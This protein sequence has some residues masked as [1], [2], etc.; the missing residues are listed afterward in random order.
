M[1]GRLS[2][3]RGS[4]LVLRGLL[5]LGLLL[6]GVAGCRPAAEQAG[7]ME[8]P[9]P[10]VS[11]ANP[12]R[13]S[14]V[15][16]DKYTG[17]LAAVQAVDVRARV[18]GHLQSIHFAEGQDVQ[19][20]DL[21]FVI[22]PRPLE[23]ARESAVAKLDEARAERK[24]AESLLG[25]AKAQKA[26][27]DAAAR[28]AQQ[29]IERANNLVRQNAMSQE[30]YDQRA[31][32]LV[33]AN[34]DVA[35]AEANVEAAAANVETAK[36]SIIVS[37]EAVDT[38]QLELSYTRIVAPIDGRISNRL[39]TPGNFVNGGSAQA[40]LLTTIV[41]LNPIHCYFDANE[42]EVLRYTRMVEAGKRANAREGDYRTPVFMRLTDEQGFPHVGHLDFVDNRVDPNTGTQ[43][44]RA[45]FPNPY[46][47]LTP[48][49]FAEVRLPGGNPAETILIPDSAVGTDQSETFVYVLGD[50]DTIER[51][52]VEL[53]PMSHG[54]RI[55]REGLS[56]EDR[57]VTSGI[58]LIR[59]G[60][61]VNPTPAE[62]FAWVEE[63]ELPDTFEPVPRERWLSVEPQTGLAPNRAPEI[64][65]GDD[66]GTPQTR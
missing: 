4:G 45:I 34:A 17:R 20:G 26:Q 41:S 50:G 13:R 8:M 53:G 3:R 61:V 40:T 22:D 27:A 18:G 42:R 43:R 29:R 25:Q 44:F 30:E 21:L 36:A 49:L 47:L 66:P 28:L 65:V 2:G 58:Q 7:P 62:E 10:T 15:E 52:T 60:A 48:G 32:E 54:L 63:G 35:A 24:R 51:R 38:A 12:L 33:Q 31:S 14:I 55:V 59:P 16:W 57:L 37:E 9:P 46:G 11:V 19:A 1:L 23:A 56:E 64:A 39:V 6:V 5:L